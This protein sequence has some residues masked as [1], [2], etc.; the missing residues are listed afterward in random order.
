MKQALRRVMKRYAITDEECLIA[1]TR[2][3]LDTPTVIDHEQ[4]ERGIKWVKREIKKRCILAKTEYTTAKWEE[5]WGYFE[6]TWLDQYTIDVWNVFG[7]D[8]ELVARANNSLERFN[9][10]LNSRFPTPHPSMA[11][12][13]TVIKTLAAEYVR[14]IRDIRRS[15]ARRVPRERIKLIVPVTIPTDIDSDVDEATALVLNLAK[16]SHSPRA[17]G[18]DRVASSAGRPNQASTSYDGKRQGLRCGWE[19]MSQPS[20]RSPVA[21]LEIAPASRTKVFV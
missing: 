4:V 14:R 15:R 10:E 17:G 16:S 3:V 2:G 20:R 9:R 12:F 21:G 1:M 19:Q 18:G 8:N 7:L 13:V 11:T 5:F 6:R